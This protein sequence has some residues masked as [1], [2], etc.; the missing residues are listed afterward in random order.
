MSDQCD[1]GHGLGKGRMAKCMDGYISEEREM[2]RDGM[3][4]WRLEM[5]YELTLW[6]GLLIWCTED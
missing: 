4:R 3:E 6:L 2:V 5:G 1:Y